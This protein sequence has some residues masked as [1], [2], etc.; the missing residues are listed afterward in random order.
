MHQPRLLDPFNQYGDTKNIEKAQNQTQG[1][2]ALQVAAENMRK[3]LDCTH[4]GKHSWLIQTIK[5]I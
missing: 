2:E 1:K 3:Y 4:P 5:E